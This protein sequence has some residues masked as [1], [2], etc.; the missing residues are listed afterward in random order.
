M[1]R[2]GYRRASRASFLC[3]KEVAGAFPYP[4]INIIKN[5]VAPVRVI[6]ALRHRK[7]LHSRNT[8]KKNGRGPLT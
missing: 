3:F 1:A 7:A 2:G 4:V 5:V 8:R 6:N